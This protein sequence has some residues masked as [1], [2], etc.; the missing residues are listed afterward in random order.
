MARGYEG[1]TS[2]RSAA[3]GWLSDTS[4]PWESIAQWN[5]LPATEGVWVTGKLGWLSVPLQKLTVWTGVCL[6]STGMYN[7]LRCLVPHAGE[8]RVVP[9]RTDVEKSEPF[10]GSDRDRLREL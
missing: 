9:N 5:H 8:E 6:F 1:R 2:L 3:G 4:Q 10:W 7:V